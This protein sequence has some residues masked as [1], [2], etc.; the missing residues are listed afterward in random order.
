MRL[1]VIFQEVE[2]I[3]T[4]SNPLDTMKGFWS[5]LQSWLRPHRGISQEKRPL[6]LG[7]FKFVH[8][9]RKRGKTLLHALME[10]LVTE[11]PGIQYEPLRKPCL[12]LFSE[13]RV[14]VVNPQTPTRTF[15]NTALIAQDCQPRIFYGSHRREMLKNGPCQGC[16]KNDS[17]NH[18]P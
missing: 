3:S 5:L 7:F 1:L 17:R 4:A 14:I 16:A 6:S 13:V 9:I 2:S 15:C 10:L 11:D 18:H 12:R 8:T